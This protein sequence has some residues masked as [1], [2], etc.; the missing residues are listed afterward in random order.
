MIVALLGLAAVGLTL[1][2]EALGFNRLPDH[3]RSA[4]RRNSH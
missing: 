2:A 4:L 1:R 3:V